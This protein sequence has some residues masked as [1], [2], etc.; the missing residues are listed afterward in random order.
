MIVILADRAIPQL[1]AHPCQT[2]CSVHVCLSF[3]DWPFDEFVVAIGGERQSLQF[4]ETKWPDYYPDG[5]NRPIVTLTVLLYSRARRKEICRQ[6]TK[7][8]EYCKSQVAGHICFIRM[9]D[10]IEST[11]VWRSALDALRRQWMRKKIER[12]DDVRRC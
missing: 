7:N 10:Q 4:S 6:R 3:R 5:R 9:Y 12:D 2:A 8:D 1:R 11:V